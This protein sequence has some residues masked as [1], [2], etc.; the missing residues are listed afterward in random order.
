MNFARIR[1]L[2][3]TLT[4][5]SEFEVATHFSRIY[6]PNRSGVGESVSDP[7][8][9]RK[10]AEVVRRELP[11]VFRHSVALIRRRLNLQELAP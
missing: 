8:A 2:A 11:R 1:T 4:G 7:G 9:I 10:Q 6:G 3:R 5:R